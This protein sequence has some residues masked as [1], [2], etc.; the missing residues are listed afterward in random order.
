MPRVSLAVDWFG[1]FRGKSVGKP[2]QVTHFVS[3]ITCPVRGASSCAATGR[4]GAASRL[5]ASAGASSTD[6]APFMEH[7]GKS[8]L[9]NDFIDGN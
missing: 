5:A 7:A 3:K 8:L 2:S 1:V 6:T 9:E 4:T